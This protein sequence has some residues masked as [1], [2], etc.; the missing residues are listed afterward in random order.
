MKKKVTILFW[1]LAIIALAGNIWYH[2]YVE[3]NLKADNVG[4]IVIFDGNSGTSISITEKEDIQYIIENL[5]SVRLERSGI[6]VGN[7]G[8]RFRMTLYLSN[9]EKAKGWNDFIINSSD[10]IRKDPFFYQA[11]EGQIDYEYLEDLVEQEIGK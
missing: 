8:Y 1:I 7:M 9:G 2:I 4:N 6:A 3:M 10:S 5:N 11:I